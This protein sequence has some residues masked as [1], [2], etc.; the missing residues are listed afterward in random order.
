MTL[1]IGA[2]LIAGMPDFAMKAERPPDRASAPGI[3][4]AFDA[5]GMM[6]TIFKWILKRFAH[7]EAGSGTPS[8]ISRRRK[9]EERYYAMLE[10]PAMAA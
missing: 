9:A 8:A 10:Q 1:P 6:G 7:L 2:L 4:S 3:N 5:A